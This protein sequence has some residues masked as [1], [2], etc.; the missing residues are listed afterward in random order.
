[1]RITPVLVVLAA[2]G[3]APAVASAQ[4][5]PFFGGGGTAYDP[6][7]SVVNSGEVLDAQAVVSGN[8]KYVT[9]NTRASSSRLL[10]LRDFTF[11]GS[12]VRGGLV[13]GAGRGGGGGANGG[14]RDGA[15]GA[16][17]PR[18]AGR[19]GAVT[20]TA[21]RPGRTAAAGLSRTTRPPPTRRPR[22]RGRPRPAGHDARRPFIRIDRSPV[23]RIERFQNPG[24]H[25]RPAAEPC[26]SLR[27]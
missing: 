11:V 17:A 26:G 20:R 4:R 18:R 2:S 22:Q 6:E 1:M 9:I 12:G 16:P 27:L 23:S 7:I 8:M 25:P 5:V 13:G 10:A 3:L 14:A 24:P 19:T 21:P 15:N